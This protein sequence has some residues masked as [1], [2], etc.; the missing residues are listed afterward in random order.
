MEKNKVKCLYLVVLALF[1]V[2]SL[3]NCS[4][5]DSGSDPSPTP[6][7]SPSPTPTPE[8]TP[9]YSI[10]GEWFEDSSSEGMK[11]LDVWKFEEGNNYSGW[12]GL[13]MPAES[14]I[15]ET[16]GTYTIS[17]KSFSCKH[18]DP[19]SKLNV[20]ENYEI[21]LL[22]KYALTIYVIEYSQQE[23]YHRIVDT[24][25]LK[26]GETK[27]IQ[28]DDSK[29][30]PTSYYST[31]SRVAVVNKGSV[32]A[33]KRG[34]TYISVASSIGTAVIRVIVQDPENAFD[35]YL[36]YLGSSIDDVTKV[37]GDL[38]I[39]NYLEDKDIYVRTFPLID[40]IMEDVEFFY[41]L[42]GRITE[43]YASV[44]EG[45]D[46]SI[47][48][49]SLAKKYPKNYPGEDCHYYETEKNGK[50]ITILWNQEFN[51]VSYNFRTTNKEGNKNDKE[52]K[53]YIQYYDFHKLLNTSLDVVSSYLGNDYSDSYIYQA[54]QQTN[55]GAHILG[56]SQTIT[57]GI[58]HYPWRASDSPT[59]IWFAGFDGFEYGK[60]YEYIEL[61]YPA[62]GRVSVGTKVKIPSVSYRG[63][64]TSIEMKFKEETDVNTISKKI[65]SLFKFEKTTEEEDG[66]KTG[67]YIINDDAEARWNPTKKIL[68][69]ITTIYKN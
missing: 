53:E 25:N 56:G 33:L 67:Y 30:I 9:T 32:Q 12:F 5:T 17:G 19:V 61:K 26:V 57:G 22:D 16:T 65:S 36:L 59:G 39:E 37:F 8:P 6:V 43:I 24:F 21:K 51:Y 45:V 46:T 7:P 58:R 34:T 55:N 23:E 27:D 18:V 64:V 1:S 3:T 20:V 49:Q 66:S 11:I 52:Q 40:E 15:L 2:I 48:T 38:Y 54:Q 13:V 4:G 28:I 50:E 35:D 68:K 69:Y 29:F 14:H 10:V 41:G 44:R 42:D 31:D 60:E 62:L 47:I 63:P